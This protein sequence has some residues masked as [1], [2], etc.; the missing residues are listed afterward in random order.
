M[1]LIRMGLVLANWRYV[2]SRWRLQLFDAI[3]FGDRVFSS[4]RRMS[5]PNYDSFPCFM[6]FQ[7]TFG[8][9][10]FYFSAL[11]SRTIKVYIYFQRSSKMTSFNKN[12]SFEDTVFIYTI[13]IL[14][15][16]F[17]NKS[18]YRHFIA[19]M[20]LLLKSKIAELKRG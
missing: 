20:V 17:N 15:I 2:E 6:V 18:C 4:N 13:F 11:C 16:T 14:A 7:F 19:S 10:S 1:S 5:V 9:R 8:V 3:L 12:P